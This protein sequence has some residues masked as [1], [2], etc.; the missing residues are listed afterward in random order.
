MPEVHPQRWLLLIGFDFWEASLSN[1]DLKLHEDDSEWKWQNLWHTNDIRSRGGGGI[2]PSCSALKSGLGPTLIDSCSP[3]VIFS[4]RDSASR[5]FSLL[6][7]SSALVN[8]EMNKRVIYVH[9]GTEGDLLSEVIA[10][11]QPFTLSC[12]NAERRWGLLHRR[13]HT[14]D[15]IDKEQHRL[16]R[17][18][19]SSPPPFFCCCSTHFTLI[20]PPQHTHPHTHAAAHLQQFTH[21]A[22]TAHTVHSP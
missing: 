16:W 21:L 9:R 11:S 6:L 17:W 4:F 10:P 20:K 3:Q 2:T 8:L 14:K 7:C 1:E 12:Q 18:V 13:L 22:S 5:H 15:I 19:V